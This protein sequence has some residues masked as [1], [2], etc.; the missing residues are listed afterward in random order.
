MRVLA[1]VNHEVCDPGVFG[2]QI[3]REGHELIEWHP[4]TGALRGPLSS[5]DA[6]LALGGGMQPD[7]EQ[8]HPWLLSALEVLR[9]CIADGVPTL[10][11]CLGGQML[12]RAAGGNVGPAPEA[13]WGWGSVELTPAAAD[14]PLFGGLPSRIEVFQ[15]H[16]FQFTLPPGAVALGS[17]PVCLQCIRV[18]ERAWGVQWHPE[19]TRSSALLWAR[20]HPPSPGGVPVRI[21]LER[22]EALVQERI[23]A[24]NSDGRALCSRF[25][26]VAAAA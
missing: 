4:S 11:L 17:S 1:I 20:C 12:A 18:G 14:D 3:A 9:E 8:R 7:D 5:F 23:A 22:F 26:S 13:E 15:W 16:S 24:C 25:L 10:G 19:V 6:V 21:D 2:E